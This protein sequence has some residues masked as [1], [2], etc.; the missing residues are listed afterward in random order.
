MRKYAIFFVAIP[1]AGLCVR[2][3]FWQ[4]SRLQQRQARNAALRTALAEPPV[5]LAHFS[6]DLAV[7]RSVRA[8]GRFDY[9]RQI[10][11]DA[12][13]VNGVPAVIIV[14]PLRL[15]D[16]GA[17]LIDRGWVPSPDAHRVMLDSLRE[18]DSTEVT[19]AVVDPGPDIPVRADS[20]WPKHVQRPTPRS[21]AT[22]YPYPV[23]PYIVRRI[24]PPGLGQKLLSVPL[25]ELTEGPH[26][27]YAIQWF[28]FAI[29]A[30]VGS[31]FLFRKEAR[32]SSS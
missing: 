27:S 14:T 32:G 10:V 30:L 13:A 19:G 18:A 29:I 8:T 5:D 2:L 9:D 6:G 23:R 28:A 24:R 4:V 25:P 26:L 3:G 16:G 20:I 12:S 22:L 15:A 1:V 17:V 31:V 21:L 7:F 11:V